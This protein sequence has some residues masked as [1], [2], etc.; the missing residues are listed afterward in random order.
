M[1]RKSSLWLLPAGA[2]LG[3]AEET[4]AIVIVVS[5]ETGT[6]S[7]ANR[8]VIRRVADDR[9]LVDRV[10]RIVQA[11]KKGEVEEEEA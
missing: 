8:G 9:E 5:E 6:I 11:G 7:I 1:K 4:D 2:G 3:L 10:T